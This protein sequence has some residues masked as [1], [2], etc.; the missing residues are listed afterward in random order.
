MAPN[1][2]STMGMTGA[3]SS[4]PWQSSIEKLYSLAAVQS[5]EK[6]LPSIRTP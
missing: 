4:A 1:F 3:S 6:S 2:V 5:V